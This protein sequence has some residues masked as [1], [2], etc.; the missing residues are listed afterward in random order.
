MGRKKA[1]AAEREREKA[2]RIAKE[3][4]SRPAE[5]FAVA[6]YREWQRKVIKSQRKDTSYNMPLL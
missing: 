4:N 6:A 3:L 2:L 5:P 1:T